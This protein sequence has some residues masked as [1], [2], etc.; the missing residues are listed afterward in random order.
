MPIVTE[1]LSAS[2]DGRTNVWSGINITID[3]PG[4]VGILGPNGVGKS[5]LMYTINKI[6]DPSGGHVY[7]GGRDIAEM[8][9]KDIARF[10]A[11]VPQVSNETFSMS[12]MDTVL[13]GRY[14]VSG[15]NTSDDD[16]RIAAN[17]LDLMHMSEFAM[18]QFDELSAGQH[19]KVM[20]A[21]GLAQEPDILMLDE[22]TA[23]LDVYYQM[24]VMKILREIA[25]RNGIIVLTICH[26]LNVASR[27]CDR[28]ILLSD[29]HVHSDGTPEQVITEKNIQD[30]YGS[31]RRSAMWTEGRISSST[32]TMRPNLTGI[33]GRSIG[34]GTTRGRRRGYRMPRIIHP[35]FSVAASGKEQ[36]AEKMRMKGS[37]GLPA[38]IFK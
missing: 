8:D 20:I 18:R 32:Q 31:G 6:I 26:D 21:R 27:F 19:Q 22:P 35:P 10:V 28:V 34:W 16:I 23:N 29:G 14:P 9:Y 24:Y 38:L 12:V 17:C 13:M 1:D 15:F 11:Y 33:P 36:D 5:T 37:N 4:L 7:L 2:Y 3:R 25:H 30:V